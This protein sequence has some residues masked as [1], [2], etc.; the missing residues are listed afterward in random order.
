MIAQWFDLLGPFGY[1][2]A[3]CS[4][5]LVV[6]IAERLLFYARLPRVPRVAATATA[7]TDPA[8]G[9]KRPHAGRLAGG[10]ALMRE[11]RDAGREARDEQVS[12]WIRGYAKS[13]TTNHRWI[14]LIAA[15]APMFGLLGT[16]LGM[17]RAFQGIA[18]HT[19]PVSP[20]VLSSGL[21][22]AMLTTLVGLALAVPAAIA[23]QIFKAIAN[24]HIEKVII[25]LSQLS[26]QIETITSKQPAESG[27][28]NLVGERAAA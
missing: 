18:G 26:I 23:L 22:E 21:W 24:H 25:A 6:F 2:L 15:L 5:L 20:Q 3:A 4:I 12:L 14:G 17:T 13:L 28:A 1:P 11:Y 19:G 10:L 9:G 16:V 7:M 8:G 27:A